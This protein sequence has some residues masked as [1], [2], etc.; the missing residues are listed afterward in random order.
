[1]CKDVY[2]IM[3]FREMSEKCKNVVTSISALR[4]EG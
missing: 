1:M 4:A 3:S 2:H